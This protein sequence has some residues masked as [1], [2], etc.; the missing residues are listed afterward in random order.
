MAT[1]TLRNNDGSVLCYLEENAEFIKIVTK[2]GAP[3]GRYEK[4]SDKTYRIDGAFIGYGNLLMT[5]L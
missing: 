5:L 2:T 4:R 1:T 3:K